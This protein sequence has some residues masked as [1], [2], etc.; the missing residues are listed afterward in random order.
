M[1]GCGGGGGGD[2]VTFTNLDAARFVVGFIIFTK[3]ALFWVIL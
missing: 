3:F 1:S 2:C